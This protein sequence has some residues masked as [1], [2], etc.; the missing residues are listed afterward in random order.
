M[1]RR[2]SLRKTYSHLLSN[3][4]LEIIASP[5]E[6]RAGQLTSISEAFGSRL[7]PIREESCLLVDALLTCLVRYELRVTGR[8]SLSLTA[9][10]QN[11]AVA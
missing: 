1:D 7:K 11:H 10:P 8:L 2:Q 6:P 5:A 9:V 4:R 3:D